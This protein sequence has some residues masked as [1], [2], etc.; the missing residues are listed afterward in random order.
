MLRNGQAGSNADPKAELAGG[1]VEEIGTK[2]VKIG[3]SYQYVDQNGRSKQYMFDLLRF[4]DK[5]VNFEVS[6][7]YKDS[8]KARLRLAEFLKR[9]QVKSIKMIKYPISSSLTVPMVE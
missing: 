5:I 3:Y 9:I 8:A 1:K 7:Q 2:S 4:L 6:A